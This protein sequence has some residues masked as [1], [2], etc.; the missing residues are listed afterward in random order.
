MLFT[1]FCLLLAA[2]LATGVCN[3]GQQERIVSGGGGDDG[4]AGSSQP[5]A[6]GKVHSDSGCLSPSP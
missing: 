2:P 4:G 3:A 1:A 6:G 5:G